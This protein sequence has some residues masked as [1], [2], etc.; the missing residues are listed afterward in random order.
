MR[1]L[2][3]IE[4]FS[5]LVGTEYVAATYPKTGIY[6]NPLIGYIAVNKE[7]GL[8]ACIGVAMNTETL[9]P[10]SSGISEAFVLKALAISQNPELA[11][12][13]L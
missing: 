9:E 4:D 11:K 13:L 12:D 5:C 7:S 6:K 2:P 8:C 10:Q 3:V 1:Y